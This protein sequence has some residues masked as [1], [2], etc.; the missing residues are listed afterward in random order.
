M[1]KQ[2]IVSGK[3]HRTAVISLVSGAFYRSPSDYLLFPSDLLPFT[4]DFVPFSLDLV[5]FSSS[6]AYDYGITIAMKL[7]EMGEIIQGHE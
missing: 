2:Q 4:S 6:C 5:I 3:C 1:T 7:K